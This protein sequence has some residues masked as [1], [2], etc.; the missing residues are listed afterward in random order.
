ME[1]V[2]SIHS[3]WAYVTLGLLLLA[4][5]NFT[6]SWLQ[7]KEYS[8]N[9][10]RL[11]LFTLIVSHI[12]LLIGFAWYFMSPAYK[13]MKELGMG[14]A[15]KDSAL[16]KLVVEHPI[17]MILAVI[18]ITIGFSKHKN[19]PHDKL[20]KTLAIYYGIALVFVLAMIPWDLWF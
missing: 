12:Q 2:H 7:K 6:K 19:K 11:A 14:A 13:Q 16:R 3:W 20:F 4:V 15:M 9:D 1:I 17:M 8:A 10:L 5:I 18:F